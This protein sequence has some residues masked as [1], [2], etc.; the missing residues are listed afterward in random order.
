MT[1]TWFWSIDS[2]PDPFLHLRSLQAPLSGPL[3]GQAQTYSLPRRPCNGGV[4]AMSQMLEGIEWQTPHCPHCGGR[5][6]RCQ[7]PT[8][9]P[10]ERKDD[11]QAQFNG[12]GEPKHLIRA[13]LSGEMAPDMQSTPLLH[14]VDRLAVPSA[15]SGEKRKRT[16]TTSRTTMLQ[17]CLPRGMPPAP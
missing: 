16:T 13:M 7:D 17:P 11:G 10:P 14:E 15:D 1:S 6:D 8:F 2:K 12:M 9:A 4:L 5:W 3:P